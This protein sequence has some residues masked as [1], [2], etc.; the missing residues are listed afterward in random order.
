MSRYQFLNLNPLNKIEEDCVC[1]AISLAL[2]EDYYIILDKLYLVAE[3]FEC[4]QLCVCCYRFLL[5]NIYDLKRIEDCKGIKIKNFAKM[6]P[7]G[8]FLI[9]IDGHLTCLI[10]GVIYDLWDCNEEIID[11]IW[12]IC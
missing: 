11:L 12:E 4:E 7:R 9:R 3:L 10:D 5:D 1:R 6:N 8:T 2:E